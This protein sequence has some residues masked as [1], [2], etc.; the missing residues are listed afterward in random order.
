MVMNAN[1]RR[2][3]TSLPVNDNEGVPLG[4]VLENTLT[5]L[6]ELAEQRNAMYVPGEG[7]G[8]WKDETGKVF[9]EPVIVIELTF[10]F[11]DDMVGVE[12][13]IKAILLDYKREAKQKSVVL[14]RGSNGD[15]LTWGNADELLAKN[16]GC[17][18]LRSGIRDKKAFSFISPEFF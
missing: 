3:Y 8:W 5:A 1:T 18:S 4:N 6:Q 9:E 11:E 13:A 2:F 12:A 10:E 17:T 14:Q 15:C 7:N 16:G